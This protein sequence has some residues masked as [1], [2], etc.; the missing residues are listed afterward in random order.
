M[1][2]NKLSRVYVPRSLY[3]CLCSRTPLFL[4]LLLN[5]CLE[6]NHISAMG[7]FPVLFSNLIQLVGQIW[8]HACGAW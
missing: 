8:L 3:K 2:D 6:L 1:F 4:C 7:Q 5:S